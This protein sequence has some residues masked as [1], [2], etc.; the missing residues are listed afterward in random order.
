[1]LDRTVARA[2]EIGAVATAVTFEPLPA[3]VLNPDRFAGRISG[4]E[5]KQR[6]IARAGVDEVVTLV[7]DHIISQQSPET[8]L[9]DLFRA[10]GMR[11]L[12]VGEAFALGRNRVGDIPRI[13][14][15]GRDFGF[16]VVAVS[17][18]TDS[19]VVVSSSKI[20]AAILA[21]DATSVIRS[22]GRPFRISGEVVHGAH[23]GRTI[24][25]PTANVVPP[26]ELAPLADG[27]YASE[28]T[29]P[30]GFGPRAAMTY[31]GTRPTVNSGPRLVETHLLDFNGDLYGQ[32]LDVDIL[33]HLRGDATFEGLDALVLQ[34]Q[35]DEA[36]TR[37]F[38]QDRANEEAVAATPGEV[39]LGPRD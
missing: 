7:F 34:L 3:Q 37:R 30:D 32:H 18:L 8:F 10:T 12:W 39:Y 11:E 26:A 2:R 14:Q 20:R 16:G 25:Y 4:V 36:N 19:D 23:L 15:I 13:S 31:I 38:F 22:L 28:A 1:L 21:G 9:A 29:L 6:Q 27:I 35:A 33:R 24:G 17:R 5:E